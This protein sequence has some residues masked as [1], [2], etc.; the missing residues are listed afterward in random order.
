MTLAA[1]SRLG[2]YVVEALI[3]VGGMG[4][5]YRGR[6]TQLN[7]DVALKVLPSAF[8]AD[9]ERVARFR[10]EAQILAS[11]NHPHIAAIHGF[12][13]E[14]PS[15][16]GGTSVQALVLE[17]VDGPTLAERIMRGPLPLEQALAIARQ[18]VAALDA[19][20]EH[21]VVHRDLKPANIKVR[22][23]GT[24]KVLDFGL[25]KALDPAAAAPG[26]SALTSPAMT[27]LGVVLGTAAYMSPEQARGL[28]ADKRS[29]IW[30]FGSV[31]YEML[32]GKRAFE[33]EDSSDTMAA[34]L[35]GEPDWSALPRDVPAPVSALLRRCLAKDPARRLRDIGDARFDL[36]D[37][38]AAAAAP[39][40]R[41]TS[42]R[43]ALGWGI[44]GLA[45]G[46]AAAFGL[47]FVRTS[48]PA[49]QMR[50]DLNTPSALDPFSI[51]LSPD[52]RAI[53]FVAAGDGAPRLWLRRLD[54]GTATPL[55]ATDLA[56]YPFWSPDGRSLG[57]FAN[58]EL[59][60]I[61]IDGGLPRALAPAVPGG[62][63]DWGPDGEILFAPTLGAQLFR[64]AAGGGPVTAVTEVDE[65]RGQNG[66]RF[67]Q[68][69]PD[70]RRF[71]FFGFGAEGSRG[72]HMGSLDEPGQ[73]RWITA[74]DGA[75]AYDASGWLLFMQQGVLLA[76]RLNVA[77]AE[78][79]GE[80][81]ALAEGLSTNEATA[82]P[83]AAAASGVLAVASAQ[84]PSRLTWLDRSGRVLGTLGA[85][86][87]DDLL[88][89]E[90]S[91]DGTR[92]A[93]S[94]TQQANADVWVY[95][96]A[97]GA[98]VTLELSNERYPTWSPD[99]RELL[100]S[101]D[102][103]GPL[104][105]YVGSVAAPGRERAVLASPDRKFPSD[106]SPDGGSVLYFNVA[107]P[108]SLATRLDL[109]L[110]P[111]G[112][113]DPQARPWLATPASELWG[114]F[115]PDGQYIAY[116]S[117]ESGRLQEIYVRRFAKPEERWTISTAGGV[118]PRWSSDGKELYYIAPDRTLMA[119]PIETT[120]T[121]LSAGVPQP[122]F[123][124]RIVGGGRNV[125]GRRQ[126][127]DVAPDG[128]FLVNIESDDAPASSITL[129][130][131]WDAR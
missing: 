46:L 6:D 128:R 1:G 107:T 113:T 64:V 10:R 14:P 22:G 45:V 39:S 24:V 100:F 58:G 98:R 62:G 123:Q 83:F 79:T 87:D 76:R 8:C 80:P 13:D 91:P 15:A 126:Q 89:A 109:W 60:R 122:L 57:F 61:D 116:H 108:D 54:Q 115:S 42:A 68:F 111:L 23:D 35:R 82:R 59:K 28:A 72:I 25:A 94:R 32:S 106:W 26:G 34:V 105:L 127:Y 12:Q 77:R 86:E 84:T 52:G 38:P 5:V 88:D 75:G 2:P 50:V 49:L 112:D 95:D 55:P 19:A 74:A 33:G 69:L 47:A 66:H 110:L 44:A 114:Q 43:A 36:E 63:G 124:R 48:G 65:T 3:G 71:I 17:L 119:V 130:L 51:A 81:I 37:A 67:P 20:H 129:L 70:G 104:D 31:L 97:R 29:D 131:N 4:E 93:V 125:I 16:P 7:R 27:R 90:I 18:I 101:S 21:G 120:A 92:V 56:Q 103:N 118:Y 30:A 11:L 117:N 40:V 99:G 73:S 9:A 96:A 102:R 41:R 85:V 78:L 53:A 121:E